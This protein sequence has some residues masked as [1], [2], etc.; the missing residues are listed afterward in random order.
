MA[1]KKSDLIVRDKV[2]DLRK[3]F[4]VTLGDW[5][6]FEVMGIIKGDKLNAVGAKASLDLLA[7]MAKKAN[8]AV[9]IEDVATIPLYDLKNWIA[10]LTE[11]IQEGEKKAPDRPT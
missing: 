5:V 10:V 9:T 11:M 3:A 2:V 4:P 7:H 6:A 8:D 1:A